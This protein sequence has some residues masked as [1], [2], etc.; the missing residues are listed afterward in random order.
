MHYLCKTILDYFTDSSITSSQYHIYLYGLKCLMNEFI[1]NIL[2]F[3]FAFLFGTISETI[4]WSISFLLL[5][6]SIGGLHMKSHIGCLFISTILGLT[7]PLINLFLM[8]IPFKLL[9]F[10]WLISIIYIFHFAPIE[11]IHH[12]L[13]L[14]QKQILKKRS[15]IIWCMLFTLFILFRT[16]STISFSLT[17]GMLE[18]ISLSLTLLFMKKEHRT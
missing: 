11:H 17:T 10:L 3:S 6:T 18:A 1:A 15:I 12:P 9:L 5:R 4:F 8:T 13:S 16:Q 7:C 14:K 2:L